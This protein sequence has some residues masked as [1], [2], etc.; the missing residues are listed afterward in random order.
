[1]NKNFVVV[2]ASSGIGR[3][4]VRLLLNNPHYN[5]FALSRKTNGLKKEFCD[6][7]NLRVI[8]FDLTENIE[9]QINNSD[10]RKIKIDYLINNAGLLI[11]K[12]FTELKEEDFLKSYKTNAMG[13][14][15]TVQSLMKSFNPEFTHIVNI[16][17]MGA[18]QGSVKFPELIAYATSKSA[19][20]NFTELFASE[21]YQTNIKMNCLC[22][23]AVNTEMLRTAFPDYE[24]D[25]DPEDMARYIVNF[26]IN[27]GQFLNGK[28]LP[29]SIST[30]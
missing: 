15:Q 2:G 21:F 9:Y 13:V 16:S 18:F 29:V 24:A 25:L 6:S 7:E 30:P 10:L 1:M 12:T 23:G 14:M 20:C 4:I 19:L 27:S 28:V 22:L 3:E 11:K 5:V 8:T 17:T 26:T